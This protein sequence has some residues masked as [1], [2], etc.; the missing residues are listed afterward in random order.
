MDRLQPPSGR[1]KQIALGVW[2]AIAVLGTIGVWSFSSYLDSLTALARTDRE[3]ALVQF[4]WRVLPVFILLVIVAVVA[5]G[6]LLRQGVRIVRLGGVPATARS[7][8]DDRAGP[9]RRG[10]VIGWILA[11]AGFLMASVPLAM[12]SLLFWLLGR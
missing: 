12:L 9:L 6:V 11:V 1:A 5:G 8:D 2:S 3:A 4:R 7:L 10:P